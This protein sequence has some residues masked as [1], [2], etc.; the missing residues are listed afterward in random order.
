[1]YAVVRT[2][3]KQYRVQEGDVLRVEK[4]EAEEGATCTLGEVLM[5]GTDGGELRVG[6][7][8]VEGAQVRVQIRRHGK[9]EK[10]TIV[11]LRRRKHYRRRRGHRQLFTEVVVQTIVANT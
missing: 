8:L 4:L 10:V 1:M 5:L 9:G 11:K 3:G 2:G 6:R 7:P